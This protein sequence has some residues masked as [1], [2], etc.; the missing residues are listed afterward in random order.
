MMRRTA[1]ALVFLSVLAA[2]PAVAHARA[3]VGMGDQ[4]PEMFTD[5]RFHWLG[6][7]PWRMV[8]SWDVMRSAS[9]RRWAHA[10]LVA[11]RSAKVEP[12]VSFGHGWSGKKRN[13]LPSV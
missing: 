8:V 3:V 2:L 1:A 4:K 12:L 10:W 5:A 13:L 9:E 11:A 7:R 6:V